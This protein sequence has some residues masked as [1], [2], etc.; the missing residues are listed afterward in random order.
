MSK[1]FQV[2]G[3]TDEMV[4]E[5]CYRYKALLGR[6]LKLPGKFVTD[7]LMEISG[8]PEKVCDAKLE[9]CSKRRLIE[10]GV[11]IRTCWWIGESE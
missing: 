6:T 7:H 10:Y 9:Q 11:S 3:I 2:K 4:R 8:Y 1:K 5:A